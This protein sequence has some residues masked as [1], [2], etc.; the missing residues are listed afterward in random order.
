MVDI[1]LRELGGVE[2][3]VWRTAKQIGR[4]DLRGGKQFVEGRGMTVDDHTS[5]TQ[6]RDLCD[7]FGWTPGGAWDG[8]PVEAAP[9]PGLG[10]ALRASL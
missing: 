6:L 9:P 3:R 7:R 1:T 5:S 10:A 8:T 4:P 2:W